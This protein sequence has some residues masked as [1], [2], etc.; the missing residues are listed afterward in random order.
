[1]LKSALA[2]LG[3]LAISRRKKEL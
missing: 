1:M 2:A 3:F